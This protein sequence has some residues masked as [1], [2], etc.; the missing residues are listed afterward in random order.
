MSELQG[1]SLTTILTQLKTKDIAIH[2]QALIAKVEMNVNQLTAYEAILLF[3]RLMILHSR[4]ENVDIQDAI[5]PCF[6]IFIELLALQREHLPDTFEQAKVAVVQAFCL[7]YP[8]LNLPPLESSRFLD[9]V[10]SPA[11]SLL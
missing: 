7:S 9:G 8:L 3:R 6:E 1:Q 2:A 5:T 4:A 10:F 11:W